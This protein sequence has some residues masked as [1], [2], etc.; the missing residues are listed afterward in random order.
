MDIA[1]VDDRQAAYP[2]RLGP[3]RRSFSNTLRYIERST[4]YSGLSLRLLFLMTFSNPAFSAGEAVEQQSYSRNL[5]NRRKKQRWRRL[6]DG[7][8]R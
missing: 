3:L 6:Y 7:P 5:E 2:F 4:S 1:A 8:F